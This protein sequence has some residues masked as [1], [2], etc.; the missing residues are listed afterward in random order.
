MNDAFLRF[1]CLRITGIRE[2][3]VAADERRLSM[4]GTRY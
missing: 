3:D 1:D 2:F 4:P